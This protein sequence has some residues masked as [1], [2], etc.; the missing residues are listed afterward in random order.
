[1]ND[2]VV[3]HGF[4][5]SGATWRLRVA[6]GLKDIPYEYRSYHLR[7]G[8]QKTPEFRKLN[9]QGLVPAL[10]IDGQVLTQSIAIC[11]YLDGRSPEVP[12][13]PTDLVLRAKVRAFALTIA[14]DVHP[15]QNLGT[16][17][18]LRQ[19]GVPQEQVDGWARE[20]IDEGLGACSRLIEGYG[21]PFCFGDAITLADVV[22]IAQLGNARRFG[23]R[24]DWPRF[25]GIEAA[26]AAL[27]AFANALPE[28]QPDAE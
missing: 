5:R 10:E 19:L 16:L 26:C 24:V 28:L 23:A 22:L 12:L 3:L 8:A 25:A 17:S 27:P 6:L 13:L 18:R 7:S 4:W 15:L 2:H 20:V 11:E 21:G 1:M 14:C 9:P